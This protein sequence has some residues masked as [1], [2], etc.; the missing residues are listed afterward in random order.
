[1]TSNLCTLT[2]AE[3]MQ[4][5]KFS[6]RTVFVLIRTGRLQ[7]IRP[8][9]RGKWHVL[10]DSLERYFLSAAADRAGHVLPEDASARQIEADV[11]RAVLPEGPRRFC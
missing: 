7:A 5:T 6:R 2:V 10:E 11:D 3:V 4:R 1:M 8:S 9:P